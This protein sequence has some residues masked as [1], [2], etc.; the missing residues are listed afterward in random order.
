MLNSDAWQWQTMPEMSAQPTDMS[1]QLQQPIRHALLDS[2]T[3][4]D[5]HNTD[6]A[7]EAI[8]SI[9]P[10]E[11]DNEALTFNGVIDSQNFSLRSAS[12]V[13]A[14]ARRIDSLPIGGLMRL[15]LLN[16]RAQQTGDLL[17]LT[18]ALSQQH[19]DSE[20]N[21][22]QLQQ[23]LSTSFGEPL[24]VEIE[25]LPEVS[26]SPQALQQQIDQ[27]RRLYVQKVLQADPLLQS[28]QA[29]WNANWLEDSL[30]VF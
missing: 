25:Y 19:L 4:S 22:A 7:S 15:F 23:V 16:S 20:R 17:T 12:Q 6:F 8:E 3:L 2:L 24:R 1:A 30:E 5:D 27:A 9:Q 29:E 18:V 21:R 11:V 10:I 13:D 26:A 28:L 14:W